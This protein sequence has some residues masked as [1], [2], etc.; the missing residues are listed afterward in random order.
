[1]QTAKTHGP[2]LV[3]DQPHGVQGSNCAVCFHPLT[4]QDAQGWSLINHMVS[5]GNAMVSTIVM[6]SAPNVGSL[7]LISAVPFSITTRVQFHGAGEDGFD[8]EGNPLSE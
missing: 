7:G 2:S 8:A 1:M 3:P 4:V 6:E 5:K